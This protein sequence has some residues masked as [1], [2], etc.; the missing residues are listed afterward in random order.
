MTKQQKI[1]MLDNISNIAYIRQS[2]RLHKN[3]QGM[4]RWSARLREAIK[5]CFMLEL[6]TDEEINAAIK[7][8]ELARMMDNEKGR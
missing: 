5:I 4:D 1:L 6:L 7:S 8:G 2:A 3:K